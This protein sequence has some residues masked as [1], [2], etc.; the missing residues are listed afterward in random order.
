MLVTGL[1]EAEFV[2]RNLLASKVNYTNLLSWHTDDADLCEEKACI[3]S[4]PVGG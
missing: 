4:P 2:Q 3:I 1:C